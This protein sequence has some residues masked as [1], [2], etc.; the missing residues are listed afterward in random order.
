MRQAVGKPVSAYIDSVTDFDIL[1]EVCKIR[2][3]SGTIDNGRRI[4][5]DAQKIIIVDA[6]NND[7]ISAVQDGNSCFSSVK[8]SKSIEGSTPGLFRRIKIWF[9]GHNKR[10][11]QV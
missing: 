2:D 9:N 6:V 1:S 3:I 8:S 5:R 4:Y 7:N 11:Q 10:G